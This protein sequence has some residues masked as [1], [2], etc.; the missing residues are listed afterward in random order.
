MVYLSSLILIC[1][2]FLKSS[3][4]PL[5]FWNSCAIIYPYEEEDIMNVSNLAIQNIS[6]SHNIRLRR[7]PDTITN[8]FHVHKVN[9]VK[10]TEET[11]L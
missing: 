1:D 10:K 3:L 4:I 5:S 6:H 8:K 11:D 9:S 2:T 7:L